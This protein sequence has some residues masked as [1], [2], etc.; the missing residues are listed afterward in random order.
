MPN[1]SPPPPRGRRSTEE[2]QLDTI[3]AVVEL[4]AEDS[5]DRLTTARTAD[6]IVVLNNGVMVETGNHESLMAGQ[7]FYYRL[8]HLQSNGSQGVPNGC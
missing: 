1:D 8:Y 5:P 6:R 4:A 2:R 7:G 3:S